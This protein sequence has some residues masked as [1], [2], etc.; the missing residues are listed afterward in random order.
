MCAPCG[1]GWR[2]RVDTRQREF[3]GLRSVVELDDRFTAPS[4][5]FGNAANYYRTQ[6]AIGFLAGLRVPALL[7]QAKD[8][9]FVPFEV[10][11]SA[12]VRANPRIQVMATEH[13]GHLGFIGRRP[14][15]LWLDEVIMEWIAG[16]VAKKPRLESSKV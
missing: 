9:T 4:F 7:I 13:G 3:T 12:A 15:R 5:G 2:Q 1:S 8:D 16:V 14:N 11:E 10:Y 6:S